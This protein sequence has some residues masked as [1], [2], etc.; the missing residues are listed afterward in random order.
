MGAIMKLLP[1]LLGFACLCAAETAAQTT[2]CK[3]GL[4]ESVVCDTEARPRIMLPSEHRANALSNAAAEQELKAARAESQRR[5]SQ[6]ALRQQ[7]GRLAAGGRCDEAKKA[8][9]AEGDFDLAERAAAL[10]VPAAASP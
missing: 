4:F 3:P 6:E 5:Q 8:A 1:I 9:L 10:C 7:V 2:T